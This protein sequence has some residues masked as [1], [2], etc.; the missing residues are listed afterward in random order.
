MPALAPRRLLPA[1]TV[2][3]AIRVAARRSQQEVADAVGVHRVTLARWESGERR[4][5]G[6]R[7]EIYAA[8]LDEM[9]RDRP[10]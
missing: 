6:H 9:Q 8:V 5:R 2:A 4:P 7:R 10:A 1:P 3:R